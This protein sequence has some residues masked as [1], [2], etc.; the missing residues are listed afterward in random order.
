MTVL[1][2]KNCSYGC[3]I[4]LPGIF[5]FARET[6]KNRVCCLSLCIV[7]RKVG[8]YTGLIRVYFLSKY[9]PAT[10]GNVW[11]AIIIFKCKT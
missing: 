11:F 6:S 9:S 1:N 8:M 2:D 10:L 4:K 5:G 7:R 3:L